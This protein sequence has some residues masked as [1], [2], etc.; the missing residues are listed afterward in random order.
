VTKPTNVECLSSLD[1]KVCPACGGPKKRA[2][3][4]CGADFFKLP[5]KMQSALYRG[6]GQGYAEAITAALTH[7]D[8]DHF[9][10]M[11]PRAENNFQSFL[12]TFPKRGAI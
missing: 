9:H 1:S 8:A 11:D 4:L 2:H 6:I 3:S 10:T 5:S 7:L 12:N